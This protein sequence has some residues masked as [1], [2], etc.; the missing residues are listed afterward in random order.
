M[1]KF[2]QIIYHDPVSRR[3]AAIGLLNAMKSSSVAKRFPASESCSLLMIGNNRQK[4][5]ISLLEALKE[6]TEP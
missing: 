3:C 2:T 5:F 6:T 4:D 1:D